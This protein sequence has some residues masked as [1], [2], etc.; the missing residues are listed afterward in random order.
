L[1]SFAKAIRRRTITAP[2]N[3]T[4]ADLTG[5]SYSHFVCECAAA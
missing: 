2:I 4:N 1:I 5:S 3:P